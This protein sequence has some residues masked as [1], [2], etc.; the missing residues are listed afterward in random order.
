MRNAALVTILLAVSLLPSISEAG[1]RSCNTTLVSQQI[2]RESTNLV[3]FYDAPPSA[4]A[5][6]RD[7][8][9]DQYNYQAQIVCAPTRQFEAL[10]NSQ[11]SKI[12][13]AAGA[14]MDGCSV[15]AVVNNPQGTAEYADAVIDYELRNRVIQW[16]HNQAQEAA[17]DPNT[18]PTPDVGKP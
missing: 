6:L 15:G 10:L 2:C 11:P 8:I 13:V 14:N 9:L 16:K 3:I 5:E 1:N 17:S 12:L 18:I 7:A 4:F